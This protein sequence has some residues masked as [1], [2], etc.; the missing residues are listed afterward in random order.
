[1]LKP[2]S[3]QPTQAYEKSRGHF[4]CLQ[5]ARV[6]R[7][8]RPGGAEEPTAESSGLRRRKALSTSG[9]LSDRT[10]PPMGFTETYFFANSSSTVRIFLSSSP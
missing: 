2:T 5:V 3:F 10:R 1:M 9:L 6:A 4:Q 8:G 7:S